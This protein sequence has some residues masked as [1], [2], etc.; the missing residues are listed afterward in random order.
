MKAI[1]IANSSRDLASLLSQLPKADVGISVERPAQKPFIIAVVP[2]MSR[3][4]KFAMDISN[5]FAPYP[6][7]FVESSGSNFNYSK[8]CN[9]GIE[10]ALSYDPEWI[11][12]SNDDMIVVDPIENLSEA[13]KD[14]KG[15]LYT[16][17]DEKRRGAHGGKVIITKFNAFGLF[18]ELL[19]DLLRRDLVAI[20]V[21]ARYGWKKNTYSTSGQDTFLPKIIGHFGKIKPVE[22]TSF[23]DFCIFRADILRR[24]KFDEN[25]WNN[26]EDRELAYRLYKSGYKVEI[27]PFRLGSIGDASFSRNLLRRLRTQINKLYFASLLDKDTTLNSNRDE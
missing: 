20:Q 23:S 27:L 9:S 21:L 12:L 19:Q 7:V 22:Y 26:Y 8:S 4:S 15:S 25:F 17:T 10:K 24:F 14:A 11:I 13:L 6:V 3:E 2:T 16:V 1:S 5:F 18:F